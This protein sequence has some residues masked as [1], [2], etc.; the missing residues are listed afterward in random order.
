MF[1][2]FYKANSNINQYV[3]N[4]A[5]QNVIQYGQN[6]LLNKFGLEQIIINGLMKLG[7]SL[8]LSVII[9]TFLF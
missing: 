9:F 4:N 5:Q 2:V 8:K 1:S 3:I 7:F 6:Y